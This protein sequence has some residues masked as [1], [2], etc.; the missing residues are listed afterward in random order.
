MRNNQYSNLYKLKIKKT[1]ALLLTLL[2]CVGL[3]AIPAYATETVQDGLEI[4]LTTDKDEYGQGDVIEAVLTVTNTNNFVVYDVSLESVI[5]EG[6]ELADGDSSS[7]Q[8]PSLAVGETVTLTTRLVAG[9]TQPSLI[10]LWI[11]LAV[12]AGG[13]LAVAI[14]LLVKHKP[15]KRT[16]SLVLCLAMVV[17]VFAGIPL[18]VQAEESEAQPRTEAKLEVNPDTKA[19]TKTSDVTTTVKIGGD[20]VEM[21]ATVT[22]VQYTGGNTVNLSTFHKVSFAHPDAL[23]EDDVINTLLPETQIVYEGALVY[24]L[25]T[26]LREGYVFAGWYYDAA[27]TQSAD[28]ESVITRDTVLYP[29]MVKSDAPLNGYATNNYVSD[30]DI[31]DP[32]HK[33]IVKAPDLQFVKDNLAFVDVLAGNHKIDFSVTDNGDGTYAI[34]AVGGLQGGRTYQLRALDRD[35]LF[36]PV[37]GENI[38][39]RYIRFYH[40]GELQ[41]TEVRYYNIFTTREEV[42]NLKLSYGMIPIPVTQTQG[43]D[44]EAAGRLY[45]LGAD[46]NGQMSI[47]DNE[48]EGSFVYTGTK[49][50]A[51]GDVVL[52]YVGDSA[53]EEEYLTHRTVSKAT[54]TAFIEILSVDGNLYSY[55]SAELEDTLFI[56]DVLPVPVSADVDGDSA[57]HSVTIADSYLDFRSFPIESKVLNEKTIAEVGDFIAFYSGTLNDPGT[58]SYARITSVEH[59]NG[60]TVLVFEPAT[61][62]DIQTAMDSFMSMNSKVDLREEEKILL[63]DE[64]IQQSIDS[65]F[66]EK[67][68]AV[69]VMEKLNMTEAPVWGHQYPLTEAQVRN[70]G[71]NV[72]FGE[73]IDAGAFLYMLSLDPPDVNANVTTNLKRITTINGGEGL[74][75][76][77]GVYIPVGIEVVN[78]ITGEVDESLKLDLYVTLEQEFAVDIRVTADGGV[79]LVL[80]FIPTDA[81]FSLTAALDIGIYTGVGAVVMV[82][83]EKNYEKSYL[84]NELVKNDGSNGA[85][86]TSTGLTEQLNA[87][88]KDG[89]TSFFDQYKDENGNS[90]LVEAYVE[91]L[92]DEVDY[93]DI[94]A[95]PLGRIKGKIV[96]STP[97]A[98]YLIEPELV[99][100]AKLNVIL[101]TSFEAMNVKEYSFTIR[102]SLADGVDAWANVV[103]KQTPYH[104]F[105]LM[106]MGNVG[107][108]AGFRLSA[109]IGL[110]SLKLGNVGIMGELGFYLDLYGFGYYH[111]DWTANPP[112][113]RGK[114]NIQSAG[115]FYLEIGFY[116]DIDLFGGILMDLLS[117][118]IHILELEVPIWSLG[119]TRYVYDLEL[120]RDTISMHD[121]STDGRDWH[122]LYPNARAKTFNI[123]TGKMETYQLFESAL[124]IEVP[125]E[126]QDTIIYQEKYP[127]GRYSNIVYFTTEA[128]VMSTTVKLNVYLKESLF[129]TSDAY[130]SSMYD[131]IDVAS[132]TLTINWDRIRKKFEI[133]YSTNGP[134]YIYDDPNIFIGYGSGD[135]VAVTKLWEGDTIPELASINH[136]A[137][138]V[139]G[140]DIAGWEIYCFEDDTLDGMFIKDISELAGYK[141]PT[142]DILLNPRYT[143]RDDTKYTV[144]H[145]VPSLTDPEKYD[146]LLEEEHQGTS[147]SYV[148]AK[149]FLRYDL[150]GVS[151]DFSRLPIQ[152]VYYGDDGEVIYISFYVTIRADGSTV[153]E[154]YYVRDSY[155]V[156]LHANNP[157]YPYY[158]IMGQ[159][160]TAKIPY[161]GAVTDP[162]YAKTQIPGYTFLGW[163]ATADGSSGIMDQLPDALDPN[164]GD[165]T[166]YYAIWAPEKVSVKVN[167][168]LLDPH[169]DY[170]LQGTETQE[171]TYGTKLY[172]NN[173][174][175]ETVKMPANAYGNYVDAFLMIKNVHHA[176]AKDYVYFAD[177]EHVINVYYAIGYSV[178]NLDWKPF[179][180]IYGETVTLPEPE[181]EGYVF[182]GWAPHGDET[183]LYLPGQSI[184]LNDWHYYL[185]SVFAEADDTKYTVKHYLEQIDGTYAEEPDETQTFFGT[186]NGSVTPAVNTYDGFLSPTAKTVKIEAD[187]STVVSY[188]Y[189]RQNYN[190]KVAYQIEGE[191]LI[192]YGKYTGTYTYGVPFY[193]MDAFDSPLSIRR[194][195]Y[196]IVGWYLADEA[197]NPDM[198]LLDSSYLVDGDA[199]TCERELVFKPKW[200][201][202]PCEYQVA[203]YLEQL[204]GTYA[205][206]Q[207]DTLTAYIQDV[208]HAQVADFSGF[209]HDPTVAG[210]VVSTTVT[211]ESENTVLKLY[212]TRNSYTVTW[213]DY[214]G[215]TVLAT[216]QFKF[217]EAITSP[218]AT[219][220]REGYT[221]D[222]WKEFGTMPAKNTEFLAADFG[223]WTALTGPYDLVLDL[224]GD[225]MKRAEYNSDTNLMELTTYDAADVIYQ[226]APG[227]ALKSY[228]DA[229][230]VTAFINATY[231]GYTFAGWYD[232]EGNAYDGSEAMPYGNLTLTAKWIPIKISVTFHPGSYFWFDSSVEME[233]VTVEYDYGSNISLPEYF[234]MENCTITGWYVGSTQG[235]YPTIVDWPA[236]LVYGYY[237][238]FT[239]GTEITVAPFWVTNGSIRQI[240]FNG[241]G[242]GS[243]SMDN[244]C[245]DSSSAC[246][247]LSR[248]RF[249]KEGYRFVGW[250]TVADGSGESFFDGGWFN[251]SDD[252]VLYAQWEKID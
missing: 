250:N 169:G 162:G 166:C 232:E 217:G 230:E 133:Q 24:G 85:F 197:L 42:N 156:T 229:D 234:S 185:E 110:L 177:G 241:N 149:E 247:Y 224:G 109:S 187:G 141:M 195:G 188:Y 46:T 221:F 225:T 231:P 189:E 124:V 235:N 104:S 57:N 25:P 186:T 38:S 2:L 233:A 242:A 165:A 202:V 71:A 121:Y 98:E 107:L 65:G 83:T 117:F 76:F 105:N 161:G 103:D 1:T 28:A 219:A 173:F 66:I 245:F 58:V 168:Y 62:E 91:M 64:I 120:A 240:T 108:R 19:N 170:Q 27:L 213:Y 74:R 237:E 146:L 80:G 31:S 142:D 155:W 32:D 101:G 40:D 30:L 69:A 33:V 94:L 215:S 158:G 143:P 214:D 238:R 134:T 131:L 51:V 140:M 3:L 147:H 22:H 49:T 15:W 198:T 34:Q 216:K 70:V 35:Q 210:T 175:P 18:P 41:T 193:F 100:A 251:L 125:E 205:L 223:I 86:T 47:A 201:K 13:G 182:K 29:M 43:F 99:F 138:K 243:G 184:T 10:W 116:M 178:V 113:G 204:D 12:V 248:N 180:Y 72:E 60:N 79:D 61:Q 200:E 222:G 194:E 152:T 126:Y 23:T 145:L 191:D 8:V 153:I 150:K 192:L 119:S 252:T 171:H 154:L 36:D 176:Y 50:L 75:V 157:D 53:V 127:D 93:I 244:I 211:T 4:T 239:E 183:T 128:S 73:E 130:L 227:A 5:P 118:N 209:T 163:S 199:L 212:Y 52:V 196:K 39:E 88:L 220:T 106:I 96:P 144:R 246:G 137:P 160:Y 236:P 95:I 115:A 208:V 123:K 164:D 81:W 20:P 7:L 132:T 26:P 9:K 21:K 89:N 90:T 114:T 167:Y 17:S 181:K 129:A 63:E 151:V 139:P 87:M 45:S 136:M 148:S 112:E 14:F 97:V 92:N 11:L 207:T 78:I 190:I 135:Y 249:V 179:Y 59:S 172:T 228:L 56:P 68:A 206:Q 55:R 77:F 82:D 67:A 174:I 37:Y 16:V 159:T 122:K 218:D 102:A 44:I 226:I 84:W 111:Y 203:H 6:C 48:S 54:E